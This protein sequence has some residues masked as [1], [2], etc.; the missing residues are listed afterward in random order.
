MKQPSMLD[1]Q[2]I[3]RLYTELIDAQD[4]S[5]GT[6]PAFITIDALDNQIVD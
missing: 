5:L 1:P 3:A 4:P 2:V 6:R